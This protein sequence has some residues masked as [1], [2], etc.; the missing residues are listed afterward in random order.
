MVIAIVPARSGS[1]GLPDKNITTV[2]AKTLLEIAVEQGLKSSL[3]DAV[4]VTTD[5]PYYEDLAKKAGAK[6]IGLRPSE[7]A[8]DMAKTIDVL[9]YMLSSEELQNTKLVG[10]LQ[11]TSPVRSTSEIDMAI[12]IAIKTGNSVVSV[13][14]IDEPHPY[15][16]KL[17][18]NCS[19]RPLLPGTTSEVNRQGLAEIYQLTGAVY[20][21]TR[22]CILEKESLFSPD[23]VPLLQEDFV[24]ID[25]EKDLLWLQHLH[26]Q[27]RFIP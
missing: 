5:D 11:V 13:A 16:M 26:A 25:S 12:N 17:I 19:L 22:E 20:V 23:T 8:G 2:G 24:N 1:K 4:Y 7:L 15:K 10:L 27:G 6:S 3:I 14:K 9:K 18:D 21:A